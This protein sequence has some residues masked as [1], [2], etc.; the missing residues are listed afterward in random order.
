[1]RRWLKFTLFA[2]TIPL[3]V[4]RGSDVWTQPYL[5]GRGMSFDTWS[6]FYRAN[7]DLPV[8]EETNK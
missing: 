2:Q 4:E 5:V 1:L 3:L 6:H 8:R 7:L